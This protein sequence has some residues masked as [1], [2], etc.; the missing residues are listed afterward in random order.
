MWT[1]GLQEGG[2]VDGVG[3]DW[4]FQVSDGRGFVSRVLAGDGDGGCVF[5]EWK[6]SDRMRIGRVTAK[7][8]DVEALINDRRVIGVT[9]IFT[10]IPIDAIVGL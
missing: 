7:V 2:W 3:F 1:L 4:G 9:L 8:M 10:L 5:L 6:W